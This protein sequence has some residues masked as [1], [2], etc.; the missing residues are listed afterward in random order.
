MA[1]SLDPA[2]MHWLGQRGYDP[3]YGAR[4]LK[5]VIQKELMDPIAKKLLAGDLID[6]SVIQVGASED[7]LEIGRATLN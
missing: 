4:P 5:R 2:A 1:I 3:A 6:G 7:G